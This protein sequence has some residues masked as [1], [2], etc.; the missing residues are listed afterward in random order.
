MS[1][2]EPDTVGHEWTAW[3]ALEGDEPLRRV[4]EAADHFAQ[5]LLDLGE[6]LRENGDREGDEL[7]ASVALLLIALSEIADEDGESAFKIARRKAGKPVN[8][9]ER[10]RKGRRAA[11]ISFRL[12]SEGWKTEAAVEQAASETDLKRAEVFHWRRSHRDWLQSRGPN[13]CQD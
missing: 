9:H 13:N 2:R 6:R 7:T 5:R 10:A 12:E 3:Y 11:I 8:Y 1:G 4:K